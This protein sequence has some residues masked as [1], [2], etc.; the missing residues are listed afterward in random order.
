MDLWR[1]G[2][3]DDGSLAYE[4]TGVDMYIAELAE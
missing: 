4:Q 3:A 2:R 1:K